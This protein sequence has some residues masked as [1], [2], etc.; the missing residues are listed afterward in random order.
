MVPQVYQIGKIKKLI[1][2]NGDTTNFDINFRV[3]SRN[4]EIFDLLVVDQTTLDNNSNLEYKRVDNGT[5]SGNLIHDKNI[6]QNYF[7]IL[8][9]D[10]PCE[11]TVEIDKK[12]LPK[13]PTP[14][15]TPVPAAPSLLKS[16]TQDGFNWVKIFLIV[17]AIAA[18]GIG[19]YLYSRRSTENR[20]LP[21]VSSVPNVP[22][23]ASF[24]FYSPP[25]SSS[26]SSHSSP[27]NS[28]LER[29]K[30]LNLH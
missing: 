5:I 29:L 24:K 13:T 15:P 1:D 4:K 19:L 10:N 21:K 28:L 16:K 18:L 12:E 3:T 8:K 6:Y 17:G 7:L 22:Q 20:S 23:E 14:A 9:A 26:S 27:P 25:K 2:L 11:C 30:R